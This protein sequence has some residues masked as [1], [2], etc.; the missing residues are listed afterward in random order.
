V[1]SSRQD[2][3]LV[4]IAAPP[5]WPDR[6]D[7]V[8]SGETEARG[9]DRVARETRAQR[10]RSSRQLRARRSMNCAIDAATARQPAVDFSGFRSSYG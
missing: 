7:D 8:A 1:I 2:G 10:R 6:M 3:F 5:D 4:S 9:D